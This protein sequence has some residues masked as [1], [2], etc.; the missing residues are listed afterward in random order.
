[1]T[2]IWRLLR[3]VPPPSRWRRWRDLPAYAR[4]RLRL[5]GFYWPDGRFHW[6]RLLSRQFLRS[7][8]AY[9]AW[10]GDPRGGAARGAARPGGPARP[11]PPAPGGVLIC[12]R[13]GE[14][15]AAGGGEVPERCPACGTP[16]PA[17]ASPRTSAG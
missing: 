12:P 4:W 17:A 13:C 14:Q 11:G 3:F 8:R 10:L 2:A 16:Y 6:R 7:V 9:H 5:Y 1:M 15:C